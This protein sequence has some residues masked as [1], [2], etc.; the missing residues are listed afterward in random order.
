MKYVV[1]TDGSPQSDEAVRY[2]TSHALAFD[3]TLE[4]VNV[5]TP[6]TGT[7]EGKPIFEG[8]DVAA[9]DG[10]RILDRARDVARDA[11][12][13]EGEESDGGSAVPEMKGE[14]L[15]GRP[16]HAISSHAVETGADGIY[17]GHRGLSSDREKVVGSVAKGILDEAEVP[18]TVV[19]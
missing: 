4:L 1:A 9:D 2:A 12:T 19:R 6:G 16:A 8:E 7:V 14:L 13:D 15:T 10:R 3:A 11:S 5:I 18:V 17:V